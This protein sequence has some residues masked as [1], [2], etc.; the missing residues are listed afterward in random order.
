VLNPEGEKGIKMKEKNNRSACVNASLT[1]AS[2]AAIGFCN[3]A[4]GALVIQQIY[5]DAGFDSNATYQND[6]VDLYNSGTTGF[7]LSGINLEYGSAAGAVGAN[8]FEFFPLPSIS[9]ASGSYFLIEL[10][11]GTFGAVLPVTPDLVD[12]NTAVYTKPSF[13]S[14]KL[15][16]IT[17]TGSILDYVGYGTSLGSSG[18]WPKFANNTLTLPYGSNAGTAG[19]AGPLNDSLALTRVGYTGDNSKDFSFATPDPIS[20]TSVPEPATMGLF[21]AA[22]ALLLA[23]RR[24]Q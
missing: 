2:L 5:G 11:G 20:T 15:A 18:T 10:A 17:S 6:Y 9:L 22:G 23:R 4:H 7:N 12:T 24:P 21:A 1:A 19:A 14:G 3:S 13:S 8:T 16:L